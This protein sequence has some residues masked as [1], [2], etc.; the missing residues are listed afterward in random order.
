MDFIGPN[1]N[2]FKHNFQNNPKK[3]IEDFEK[4]NDKQKK[5]LLRQLDDKLKIQLERI[6]S[7]DAVGDIFIPV[8]VITENDFPLASTTKEDIDT[9]FEASS[10]KMPPNSDEPVSNMPLSDAVRYE[11]QISEELLGK[12]AIDEEGYHILLI[13][14]KTDLTRD[15]LGEE[16]FNQFSD[17]LHFLFDDPAEI[18]EILQD[19]DNVKIL[20]DL[21]KGNL[22]NDANTMLR[23]FTEYYGKGNLDLSYFE[24]LLSCMQFFRHGGEF[25]NGDNFY[26]ELDINSNKSDQAKV[27]W[28][29]GKSPLFQH[30]RKVLGAGS[31]SHQ[32]QAAIILSDNKEV[33]EVAVK[34][35]KIND[36]NLGGFGDEARLPNV[37]G[38]A[39]TEGALIKESKKYGQK[40]LI[41]IERGN[42]D[43]D[44][45]KQSGLNANELKGLFDAL[46]VYHQ[47][48]RVNRDLKPA[49]LIV[50]FDG[51]VK[52]IDRGLEERTD[53]LSTELV[54]TP[55]TIAPESV[56]K[57]KPSGSAADVWAYGNMLFQF[58]IG[59]MPFEGN[60]PYY[61]YF[62]PDD[63]FI[64]MLLDGP[65]ENL[66]PHTLFLKLGTK[67]HIQTDFNK[68][69]NLLH[70]S[71][72]MITQLS[73]ILHP[74]PKERTTMHD[75]SENQEFMDILDS[76][77]RMNR[78]QSNIAEVVLQQQPPR[79]QAWR[80]N[81]QDFKEGS[82]NSI[83]GSGTTNER[84]SNPFARG[85]NF[86]GV[87]GEAIAKQIEGLHK[88]KDTSINT[89][90][91]T[92][93][94]EDL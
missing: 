35:I 84:P 90:G 36:D 87:D 12:K 67:M 57:Y 72:I 6:R 73:N 3:A 9:V 1:V 15:S 91:D 24:E 8:G 45:W 75:L 79:R 56:G 92:M 10:A 29:D 85:G 81:S 60:V 23:L 94:V 22:P 46:V 55:N 21:E 41:L 31:F 76:P 78:V 52:L 50:T 54:G 28:K 80:E 40:G 93:N 53:Q 82:G 32:V 47:A 71:K 64:N 38:A 16:V 30:R 48:G 59:S 26:Y 20:E 11:F 88:L 27:D 68:Y 44:R 66:K 49:N 51:K 83:L 58:M 7:P 19:L 43:L 5:A 77:D 69:R 39:N 89:D 2:Q 34:N 37:D 25:D 13:D 33:I 61:N 18:P 70:D 63:D 62:E 14:G 74:D 17:M 65:I 42:Q 4:L 86:E